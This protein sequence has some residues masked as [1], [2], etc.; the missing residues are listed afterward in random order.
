MKTRGQ[1]L[2]QTFFKL[3]FTSVVLPKR[4]ILWPPFYKQDEMMKAHPKVHRSGRAGYKPKSGSNALTLAT[5]P[6][7][8]VWVT[9]SQNWHRLGTV[10]KYWVSGPTTDL[11]NRSLRFQKVPQRFNPHSAAWAVLPSATASSHCSS[12]VLSPGVRPWTLGSTPVC[13]SI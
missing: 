1:Q 6:L 5:E 4:E 7:L 8:R 2:C 3:P 9:D 10:W 12:A 11:L 13:S